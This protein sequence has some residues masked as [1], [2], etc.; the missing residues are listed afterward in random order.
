MKDNRE[1]AIRLD[2]D[3]EDETWL[4][5]AYGIDLQ[6]A[7][8]RKEA[9]RTDFTTARSTPAENGRHTGSAGQAADQD[10]KSTADEV[11]AAIDAFRAEGAEDEI[12]VAIENETFTAQGLLDE[13]EA[14]EDSLTPEA[15]V[16]ADGFG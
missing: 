15:F 11:R 16:H 14:D 9:N 3:G 6:R 13:F 8:N 10:G 4:V 7:R 12:V 5:S 1:A 2:F